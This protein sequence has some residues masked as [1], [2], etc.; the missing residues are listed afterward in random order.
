MTKKREFTNGDKVRAAKQR[1][2]AAERAMYAFLQDRKMDGQ[3]LRTPEREE[4]RLA[5]ELLDS[6]NA[7][8]ETHREWKEAS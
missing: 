1:F 7:Y 2:N 5:K 4:A 6:Y 3:A 8:V